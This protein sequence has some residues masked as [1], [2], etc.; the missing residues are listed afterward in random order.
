MELGAVELAVPDQGFG[1]RSRA[2]H[3]SFVRRPRHWPGTA[4]ATLSDEALAGDGQ[5]YTFGRHRPGT[6]NAAPA[7]GTLDGK[8]GTNAP[9]GWGKHPHCRLDRVAGGL[10]S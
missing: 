7:R 3:R 9:G 8:I 1:L 10:V 5:L 2:G 6:A 4:N